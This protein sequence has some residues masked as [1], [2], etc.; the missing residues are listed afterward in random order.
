MEKGAY[1]SV[2]NLLSRLDKVKPSG[3]G[4]FMACCPA[5]KDRTASLAIKDLGDGRIILNCFAGCDTYSILNSIGLDWADVM[6]EKA[7][8]D[9]FKPEK[10]VIYSTDAL[11]LIRH[12]CQIM[13]LCAYTLKKNGILPT[14][15]LKRMETAM[16]RVT[17]AL[18]LANVK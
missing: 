7:A 13:L 9:N 6:P 16:Q 3:N 8:G 14:D 1:M 18:E 4:S 11:R 5:H 2:D 10:Q 12:E 15:D 17:K